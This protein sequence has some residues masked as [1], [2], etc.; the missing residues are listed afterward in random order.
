MPQLIAKRPMTDKERDFLTRRLRGC[1][2]KAKR[3]RQGIVN[4]FLMWVFAMLI[5][6]VG[7][8]V[9]AWIARTTVH[10]ELGWKRPDALWI[11]PAG[12]LLCATYSIF[13][14]LRWIK[15]WRDVRPGLR[16]DLESGEVAEE[17]YE[18]TAAKR[19]QEPEHGG[20]MYFLRTT[21][22]K[23][24]VLFDYESQGLGAEGKDPVSSKFRPHQKLV[25]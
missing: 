14:T 25:L 24:F 18:F 10:A 19:F 6:V 17:H 11:L 7:W 5:F 9:M 4:A 3:L 1:P 8:K 2:T 12:A 16:A 22:D 23:V 21:D 20:L 13:S 15:D